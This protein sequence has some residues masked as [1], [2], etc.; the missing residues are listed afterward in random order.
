MPCCSRRSGNAFKTRRGLVLKSSPSKDD[1]RETIGRYRKDDLSI[2]LVPTMGALHEG[3]LSLIQYSVDAC[4]LTIVSIFVNP[5][6]FGPEEDLD[7]YPRQVEEDRAAVEATGAD[8]LFIP[9]PDEVYSEDHTVWVEEGS[10]SKGL[11]GQD[12]PGHFRGVLTIVSKLFNLIRPD[13]AFFGQKDYQQLALINRMVRDLDYQIRI[14]RVP[15]VREADGIAMSSRNLN[16]D[17]TARER[18]SSLYRGLCAALAAFK[19]GQRNASVLREVV[20]HELNLE[21]A[22]D[23][24]D[25]ID[26]VD[27]VTLQNVERVDDGDVVAIAVRFGGTRLI[28]NVVLTG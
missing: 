18:A 2:G 5:T 25:Y 10:L 9:S 17:E 1:L 11:C 22:T 4:D 16:L 8:I 27:G 15:T 28:D 20:S 24:V 14:V 13:E 12:R 6:Q 21:P 7:R 3:H 19:S 23:R 26:V